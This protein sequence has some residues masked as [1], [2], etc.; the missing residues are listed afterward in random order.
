MIPVRWNI[1]NPNINLI[2][3]F[4]KWINTSLSV[5]NLL[6]NIIEIE[7]LKK[8]S[9]KFNK[10]LVNNSDFKVKRLNNTLKNMESINQNIESLNLGM[11]LNS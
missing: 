1:K 5:E 6:G 11:N 2:I 9:L 4:Q 10:F 8:E 7:K 3:E